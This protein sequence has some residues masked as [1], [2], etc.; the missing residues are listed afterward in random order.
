L[1][2]FGFADFFVYVLVVSI[3]VRT[4]ASF[5][6]LWAAVAPFGFLLS[7]VPIGPVS[8]AYWSGAQK[9]LPSEKSWEDL[10][11]EL[12]L[13]RARLKSLGLEATRL[14]RELI[15]SRAH[16]GDFTPIFDREIE[17]ARRTQGAIELEIAG[18]E[19][20]IALLR[21]ASLEKCS[22]GSP[23]HP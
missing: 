16:A 20:R 21:I 15:A 7:S 1:L 11:A 19:S 17:E 9:T 18:L 23:P 3:L 5:F 13:A 12:A 6:G 14:E 4:N 8:W 10:I 22:V 2:Y